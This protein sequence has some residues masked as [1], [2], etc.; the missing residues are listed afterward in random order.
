VP[1]LLGGR[2]GDLVTIILKLVH[3]LSGTRPRVKAVFDTRAGSGYKDDIP[4]RYHFPN[5]YLGEC[6]RAVGDWIVYREPRRGGGREGYIAVAQI[7]GIE[8]DPA[9]PTHSYAL[10]MGFL[11]FDDVVPLRRPAGFYETMLNEVA[12]PSRI[13]AALQGKSIRGISESDFGAIVRAGLQQTLDPKN[14]VRLELDAQ[15]ADAD[16]LGFL[17]ATPGEQERRIAQMLVNRKIRD[18]A[19]RRSV[20]DAYDNR[21]AVTGLRIINGGG[22]SEAQAAHIWSVASGGPD[23]VQNGVAL[24]ATVHWLFDRHLISLTDDFGILVS[25]N[26]VPSELRSLFAR[27]LDR[28]HLPSDQRLWPHPAYVRRHREKFA[29]S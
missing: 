22:K 6:Q 20:C 2:I 9:D 10:V 15:H 13:G 26:K 1:S 5:R 18:A 28:I 12:N 11:P 27:Q 19:F 7:A 29:I 21:C 3:A 24:S 23:V 16:A 4:F 14:A 25:H 8:P 17:S